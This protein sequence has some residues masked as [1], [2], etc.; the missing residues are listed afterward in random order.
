MFSRAWSPTLATQRTHPAVSARWPGAGFLYRNDEHH[1]NRLS[2]SMG[3]ETHTGGCGWDLGGRVDLLY[4]T[5]YV[6]LQARGF[7][8]RGDLSPKWNSASGSGFGGVGLI[9][10]AMPSV[11]AE[12]RLQRTQS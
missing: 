2:L 5:D 3:R 10:L 1:F 8:T 12:V 4:G 11:Y 7:E 6:F 9:G